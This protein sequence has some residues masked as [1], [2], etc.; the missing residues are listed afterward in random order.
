MAM[1]EPETRLRLPGAHGRAVRLRRGDCLRIV[2]TH[3]TQFVDT[4]AFADDG[5]DDLLSMEHRREVLQKITFDPGD[6]LIAACSPGMYERAGADAGHANCSDNLAHALA[7]EGRSCSFTPAT[8]N[9][10]HAGPGQHGK[11]IDYVRPVV[12]R[13]VTFK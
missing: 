12:R 10:L 11:A 9:L 2:N 1:A 6:T 4:W 3:G 5:K 8:W 13:A 7:G